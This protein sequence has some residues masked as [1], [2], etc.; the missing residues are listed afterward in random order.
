MLIGNA[1]LPGSKTAVFNKRK[2]SLHLYIYNF[3]SP[4]ST[5]NVHVKVKRTKLNPWNI[6]LEEAITL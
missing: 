3:Y 5:Q 2:E 1:P 6:A 4:L